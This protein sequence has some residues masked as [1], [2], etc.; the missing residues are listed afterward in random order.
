MSEVCKSCGTCRFFRQLIYPVSKKPRRFGR[1]HRRPPYS[2][3]GSGSW[4]PIVR[5][6]DWCGEYQPK[7]AKEADDETAR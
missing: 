2:P 3:E 1:C 4:W 7:P 6:S 5:P